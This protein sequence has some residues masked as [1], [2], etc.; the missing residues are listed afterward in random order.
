MRLPQII[1]RKNALRL[2]NACPNT[3]IG[4]RN[5]TALI[6]MYRC[7]L[8]VSEVCNLTVHDVDFDNTLLNIRQGKGNKDRYVPFAPETETH[9]KSWLS[10]K[11]KKYPEAVWFLV[12]RDGNQTGPRTYQKVLESLSQRTGV[13]LQNGTERKHVHPHVLRHCYATELLEAGFNIR[14]IQ[15]LLGHES[16]DT[17]MVYT[18]V[19]MPEMVRAFRNMRP[20]LE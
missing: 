13:Y 11:N 12:T 18:Q 17:T 8:R 1:S 19:R 5:K 6:L 9:L 20:I 14:W 2:I 15:Q 16:L 7:G 10:T 4:Q 3:F